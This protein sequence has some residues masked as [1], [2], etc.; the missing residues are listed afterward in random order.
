MRVS[1]NIEVPLEPFEFALDV[2]PEGLTDV[3]M[4]ST[5]VQLHRTAPSRQPDPA[6]G[7]PAPAFF[8][9]IVAPMAFTSATC[10]HSMTG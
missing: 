8:A 6:P 7:R 3:H 10:A 5:H 2:G 1:G 9:L 4:M